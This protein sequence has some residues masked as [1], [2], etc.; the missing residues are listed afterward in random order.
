M[1]VFIKIDGQAVSV[2]VTI[3]I[4]EYLDQAKHKDENLA[5]E[6]RRHWDRREFTRNIF[7]VYMIGIAYNLYKVQD[8]TQN[9]ETRGN[10]DE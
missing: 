9:K 6:K 1:E 3:K 10:A 2:E 4:Y 5:H 7:L 8:S